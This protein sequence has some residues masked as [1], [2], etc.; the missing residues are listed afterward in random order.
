[1]RGGRAGRGRGGRGRGDSGVRV[2]KMGTSSHSDGAEAAPP[3]IE[4]K[5]R[6]DQPEDGDPP[7]TDRPQQFSEAESNAELE[8]IR[9]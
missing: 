9:K 4:L 1:M 2:S 7:L 6:L 8:E 3:A 5:Q